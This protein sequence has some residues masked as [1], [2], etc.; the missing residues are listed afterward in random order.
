MLFL[1][2]ILEATQVLTGDMAY[3]NSWTVSSLQAFA[4]SRNPADLKKS[5]IAFVAP[6]Y[7]TAYDVGYRGVVAGVTIDVNAYYNKY[8]DFIASKNAA[9]PLYGNVNFS[10]LVD[11]A[12]FGHQ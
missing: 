9:A 4:V 3:N 12:P 5:N 8:E 7:V 10:D 11:L 2:V 6:E 1:V